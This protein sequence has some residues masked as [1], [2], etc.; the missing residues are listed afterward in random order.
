M[1][2]Q[3]RY[4]GN[5]IS[6]FPILVLILLFIFMGDSVRIFFSSGPG[7]VLLLVG[8]LLEIMGI[9]AIKNILK[10]P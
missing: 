1:T 2:L 8:G 3:S 7:T 9:V 10:Q 5:I 4:S 6:S